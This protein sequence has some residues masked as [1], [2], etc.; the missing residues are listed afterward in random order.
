MATFVLVPGA[1]LGGWAWA[2]PARRLRARGHTVYSVTLT[3]LGERVHLARPDVDLETHITD[4]LNVLQY[5]GLTD[6]I[7]AGHS[8]A[9]AVIT[10]VGDRAPDTVAAAVYVDTAPPW[11][12]TSMLE[13]DSAAGQAQLRRHVEE[14]GAGWRLP[15]PGVGALGEQ[16]SVRGL[17]DDALALLAAKATPQPFGTWTQPLRL[18]RTDNPPY[19]RAVIVC[20]DMRVIRERWPDALPPMQPPAWQVHELDT[21]HWPMLSMPGELA[22]VLGRVAAE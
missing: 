2:E 13:M 10:G 7:L 17:S 5:E 8:Y 12:G 3:G 14:H 4:V 18:T 20:D 21:G 16:A 15:F 1:W 11:N 9:G 6:V 19:R 22:E